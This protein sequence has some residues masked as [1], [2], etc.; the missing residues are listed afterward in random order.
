[1]KLTMLTN[2]RLKWIIE[3]IFNPVFRDDVLILQPNPASQS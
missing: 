2:G 1:M 3:Q